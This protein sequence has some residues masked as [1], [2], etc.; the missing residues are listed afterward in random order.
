M[1][2]HGIGIRVEPVPGGPA[3]ADVL[4][5][6]DEALTLIAA[7]QPWRLAHLRR[8]VTEIRVIRFPCRGAFLRDARAIV[9]ELTF[10]ARRDISA[11]PV[12]ASLLH[13]GVHARVQA[14]TTR[15]R[16]PATWDAADEERLCRRVELAFGR[17]LPPALGAPVVTRA[18][19]ALA[20]ADAEVAPVVDW[21]EAM[22]RVRGV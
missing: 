9:C 1:R 8:D 21:G 10:L 11:A 7:S 4:A 13:E 3:V 14:M 12:A 2:L 15:W 20:L 5:R 18:A 17:A 22:A 16:W 6:L 19:D